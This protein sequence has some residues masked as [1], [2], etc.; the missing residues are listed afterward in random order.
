MLIGLTGGI[1]TGKSSVS[2][3]L[4]ELGATVID[5]DQITHALQAPGSPALTEIAEAF[6]PQVI[7]ADGNLDRE[8]VG[9][10]IFSDPEARVRL[11]KIM[12]P[13]VG[14]E[15]VRQ[16]EQARARGASLVVLDIPLL[17]EGKA[18]GTGTAALLGFDTVVLVYASPEVQIERLMKRDN[19]SREDAAMRVESQMPIDTKRE[20]ADV[21][22]DNNGS[23]EETRRAVE[24]L[25]RRFAAPANAP[26]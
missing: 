4:T 3:I 24:A 20:L 21:I 7:D 5:A 14:A 12:H 10:R 16:V 26:R 8:A 18:A 9:A 15:M 22:I 11:G 2:K 6:G 13:R 25:V 23:P 1:A 19:R 17:L